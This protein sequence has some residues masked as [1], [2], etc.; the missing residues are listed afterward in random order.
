[1]NRASQ[2]LRLFHWQAI[3]GPGNL[4][5]G[6]SIAEN[7]Q[8]VLQQLTLAGMQPIS[9]K[10]RQKLNRQYWQ[11]TERIAFIRQL[12]TL[13]QTGLPLVNSLELLAKDHPKPAWACVLI[14]ISKAVKQ[15]QPLSQVLKEYPQVFPNIFRQVISIGELTGQLENCCLQLALQQEQQSRLQAKVKK[16]LRYPLIVSVIALLVTLLMLTMV[17]PEFAKIYASFGAKLPWFTQALITLSGI[18]IHYGPY[19]GLLLGL[20][21]SGYLRYW[22]PQKQWQWREQQLMLRLPVLGRLISHSNLSQLFQTLVLTQH[23][24]MTLSA[25]LTAAAQSASNL[26]FQQAIDAAKTQ[27]MQGIALHIALRDSPLFPPLCQQLV[28]IGEESG[29]LDVLLEK[30]AQW[31]NQQANELTDNLAEMLEPMM[32]VIMGV[33]VG[34]LVIAMYLPI[35]HMGS[36]MG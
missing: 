15:G 9:V 4:H 29:S 14:E 30:L 25:G 33:I 6:D 10:S 19:L 31:H 28:R 5:F 12:A 1:M 7:P 13:L 21:C 34:G 26:H 18:L 23:A 35:F 8:R 17:L 36:A 27:L 3:D 24:G 16:A 2:R 11:G 20:L 22:H 32:M